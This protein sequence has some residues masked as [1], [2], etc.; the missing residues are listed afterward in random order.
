MPTYL[1]KPP[2]DGKL[3]LKV[4][5]KTGDIFQKVMN[6]IMIFDGKTPVIIYNEKEKKYEKYNGGVDIRPNMFAYLCE[7]LGKD[8][9]VLK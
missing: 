7:L 4:P 9:V 8:C 1:P 6:I 5:D 3:Y 2:K